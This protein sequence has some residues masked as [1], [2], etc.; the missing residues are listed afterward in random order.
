M[1]PHDHSPRGIIITG[2][3]GF[4]APLVA[5]INSCQEQIEWTLRILGLLV[6]IGVGIASIMAIQRGKTP[7]P[8]KGQ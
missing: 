7:P 8:S 2:I 4:A 3:I 6:S 5:V 1:N